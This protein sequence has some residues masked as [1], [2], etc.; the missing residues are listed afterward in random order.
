MARRLL[1]TLLLVA[2]TVLL[3]ACHG[4]KVLVPPNLRPP[5]DTGNALEQAKLQ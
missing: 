3:G 5:T 1:L 4:V 2:V